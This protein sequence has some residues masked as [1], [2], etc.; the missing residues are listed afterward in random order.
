MTQCTVTILNPLGLHARAAAM[1]DADL[2]QSGRVR[3][4]QILIEDGGHVA[5]RERVK[6]Q[7]GFEWNLELMLLRAVAHNWR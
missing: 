3:G 7:L 4:L 5:R 1:D 2:A 6:I